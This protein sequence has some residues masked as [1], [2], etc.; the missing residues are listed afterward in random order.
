MDISFEVGGP[1]ELRDTGFAR[2]AG[3]KDDM[4]G[5]EDSGSPVGT[6]EMDCPCVGF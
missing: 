4:T 3:G 1:R 2:V 5:M 6:I